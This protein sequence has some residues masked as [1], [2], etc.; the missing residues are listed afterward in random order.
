VN[1]TDRV[2]V[3]AF[4]NP[5][6]GYEQSVSPGNQRQA[7]LLVRQALALLDDAAELSA[8]AGPD[9]DAGSPTR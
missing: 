2:V 6:S 3:A 7:L 8:A 5:R 9:Q 1:L 4:L